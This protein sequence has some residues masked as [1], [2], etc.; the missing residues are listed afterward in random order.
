MKN[1]SSFKNINPVYF[2]CETYLVT[3]LK[4]NPCLKTILN[5]RFCTKFHISNLIGINVPL[6]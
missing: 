1:N 2:R 4:E 6:V 3:Q 5:E